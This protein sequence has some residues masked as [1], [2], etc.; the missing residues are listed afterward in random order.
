MRQSGCDTCSTHEFHDEEKT[1]RPI[2]TLS[3]SGPL[4]APTDLVLNDLVQEED[5][6]EYLWDYGKT[7]CTGQCDE[8]TL[9]KSY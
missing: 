8:V 9:G 1:L 2:T 6:V 3:P 4:P 5:L 7:Y